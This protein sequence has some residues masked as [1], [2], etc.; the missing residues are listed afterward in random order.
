[1]NLYKIY[2]VPSRRDDLEAAALMF[3]HLLTP[4]GLSWTRNGI[5]KN[6]A[7]HDR[8]IREKRN[9]KPEDLCKGLPAQFEEFLRYCRRL[10][11]AEC[12]DYAHWQEEFG[13]LAKEEGFSGTD[14]FIWPPPPISHVST[15][16][17][18]EHVSKLTYLIQPKPYST[19]NAAL[20][21]T[22]APQGGE[23][24]EQILNELANLKLDDRPVL[25]DRKNIINAVQQAK[26]DGKKP[27]T[28]VIVISDETDDGKPQIH[29]PSPVVAR[30]PKAI[31]LNKLTTAAYAARDNNTLSQVVL[32]FVAC[33]QSN[34]SRTLTKEGF[35]FLDAL[36]RQ[37]GDPSTFA[38]PL[39]TS[40][41]RSG[42]KEQ[43]RV[44]LPE[45]KHVKLEVLAAL[46]RTV[47]TASGNKALAKMVADFGAVT[48]KSSGRTV[49]KDGFAF[50]EGLAARLKTIR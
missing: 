48:N 32:D 39:R 17:V 2:V 44:P 20:R 12:P 14:E 13:E 9:A 3:I 50:L 22:P 45:P 24:I 33:L 38:V 1:V 26:T 25:G 16:W 8:I 41:T 6:N 7:Q 11:F 15:W 36:H 40:R 23:T 42:D 30:L 31:Q 21:R 10:K 34:R 49:T 35:A 43:Q 19:H 27:V 5:P 29:P 46:R 18:N 37:L 4:G 28:E 47:G